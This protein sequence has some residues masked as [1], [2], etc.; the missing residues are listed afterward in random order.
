M[1]FPSLVSPPKNQF[2]CPLPL[3]TNPTTPASW[4]WHSLTLGHW[5]F[6]GPRTSPPIDDW[7]GHPLLHMPLEPWVPPCVFCGWWFSTREFWGYWLVHIIVH[8]MGLLSPSDPT[9][10][11]LDPPLGTLCSAQ[12]M[13]VSLHLCIFQTLADP[14]RRQLYQAPVSKHLVLSTIVSG[15]GD[16]TWDGSPGGTVSGWSFLQSLLQV[17]LYH[18]PRVFCSLF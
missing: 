11:S 2:P 5:A 7:Q 10:F 13:S 8:L 12:W 3:F 18:F 14:F 9:V 15:F 6:T 17:S 16:I 1:L 4:S